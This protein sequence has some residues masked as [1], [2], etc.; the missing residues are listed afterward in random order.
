MF[1]TFCIWPDPIQNCAFCINYLAV[2]YHLSY[3][4]LILSHTRHSLLSNIRC[5]FLS[6]C[7]GLDPNHSVGDL[8]TFN[9]LC[10][11]W[12]HST[13]DIIHEQGELGLIPFN[14]WC[15][16]SLNLKCWA[17]SHLTLG[18]PYYFTCCIGLDPFSIKSSHSTPC[19]LYYLQVVLG[20]I[21][22]SICCSL[23]FNKLYWAWSHSTP[24][25]LQK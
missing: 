5:S 2:P 25:V 10:W 23:L 8:Y 19:V 7:F 12:S 9:M 14:P 20:L 3:S 18:P 22:F 11:A 15:P 4:G 13:I 6:G 1:L 21:S 24:D 17:W 16:S